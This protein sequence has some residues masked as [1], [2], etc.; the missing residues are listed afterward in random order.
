MHPWL[1]TGM[2]KWFG[3]LVS[4]VSLDQLQVNVHYT[5]YTEP[6]NLMQLNASTRI[7]FSSQTLRLV[8]F[9]LGTVVYIDGVSANTSLNTAFHHVVIVSPSALDVSALQ[10]GAV[11]TRPLPFDG[12]L[13]E[14]KLFSQPQSAANANTLYANPACL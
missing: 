5:S 10:L 12:I 1:P 6:R 3:G 13:D 4:T 9:P 2:S 7:D 11:T 8:G 14:V